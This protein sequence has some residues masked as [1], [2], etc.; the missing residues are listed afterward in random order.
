MQPCSTRAC[1]GFLPLVAIF[2]TKSCGRNPCA[3]REAA[4][5]TARTR[6]H[7]VAQRSLESRVTEQVKA[8][9]FK[10]TKHVKGPESTPLIPPVPLLISQFPFAEPRSVFVFHLLILTLFSFRPKA[11]PV[12]SIQIEEQQRGCHETN[13][14]AI[15]Y[16]LP[17]V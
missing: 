17:A 15:Y 14:F 4:E 5:T 13:I 6:P 7:W 10:N 2:T 1:E 3:A 12:V 9:A 16:Y 11:A 8:E